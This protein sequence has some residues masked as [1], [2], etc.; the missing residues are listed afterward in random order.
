MSKEKISEVID[1]LREALGEHIS[2]SCQELFDPVFDGMKAKADSA[3][4]NCNPQ[5]L[6]AFLADTHRLEGNAL[7]CVLETSH[8][9]P[10][11]LGTFRREFSEAFE[12]LRDVVVC[13]TLQPKIGRN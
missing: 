2:E 9:S 11:E 7:A 6:V 12:D 3:I 4:K 10:I 5:A 1:L 13:L 8:G